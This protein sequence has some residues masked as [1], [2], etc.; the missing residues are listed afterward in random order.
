MDEEDNIDISDITV[1]MSPPSLPTEG[2]VWIDSNTMDTNVYTVKTDW[3]SIDHGTDFSLNEPVEF[4]DKMP[5][6]AK[7]EDMCEDYPGLKKAYENFKSVY[8]MVHQDWR[9]KQKNEPPF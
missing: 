9:G 4:E 2:D 7:V 5:S 3:I 8:K 6:V 1:S